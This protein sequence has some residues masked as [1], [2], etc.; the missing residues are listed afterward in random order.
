MDRV[1]ELYAVDL[2]HRSRTN[3]HVIREAVVIVLPDHFGP[4]QLRLMQSWSNG[5]DTIA[6][7]SEIKSPLVLEMWERLQILPPPWVRVPR[8]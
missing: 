7:R 6:I 5:Q 4:A 3:L 8:W 1:V 2:P